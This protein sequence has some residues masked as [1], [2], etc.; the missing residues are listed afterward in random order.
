MS[1]F[2]L[3]LP[4]DR[5]P[6]DAREWRTAD[7]ARWTAAVPARWSHPLWAV[8]AL[9]AGLA[10]SI[11]AAPYEAC[12]TAQP[13]DTSWTYVALSALGLLTLYW[14]WRQPRLAVAGLLVTGGGAVMETGLTDVVT[15]PADLALLTALAFAAAGLVHRLAATHRQRA[16]AEEAAGPG[17]HPLPPEARPFRRGR[18]SFALASLLLAVTVFAVWRAE[19]IATAY[20]ER[21]A[22]AT[23]V[24]AEVTRIEIEDED[25]SEL[26][27]ALPD[28]G[29]RTVGV[30]FPEDYPVGST[31]DL[32]VDGDWARLVAEP[33]EVVGWELLALVTAVP[34]LGF[35]ANGTTGNRRQRRLDTG[36]LPVLKVLVREGHEDGRTWVY[37]ADDPLGRHPVLSFNSLY[38]SDSDEEAR[39]ED[40]PYPEDTGREPTE[41]EARAAR[42]EWE[43]QKEEFAAVLKGTD[44]PPPLREALLFGAPC[45]GGETAF[46]APAQEGG[47]GPVEA[48]RSVTPIRPVTPGLFAAGP[49]A[50]RGGPA[51]RRADSR[52]R[53]SAEVALTL[54]PGP[55]PLTWSADRGS[56]AL[57]GFLLLVQGGGMWALLDDGFSWQWLI[58]LVGVPWLVHSVSTALNWRITADRDGVWI[59]G[60]W[61]VRHVRWEDVAAVRHRADGV[62][63][64]LQDGDD[65]ELAPVGIGVDR[66]R[67]RGAGSSATRAAETLRALL[68]HPGLR[69]AEAAGP[70]E[71]G[72]PLGPVVVALAALWAA[73]V[74]LL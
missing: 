65:I 30:V 50:R 58:L 13:C 38:T 69:P 29:T 51:P 74:L 16:L 14:I 28:G 31:V 11:A 73:V 45:A 35:L 32:V 48:E 17:R 66:L 61:R 25:L 5:V 42:E 55:E 18:F 70:G 20:E 71:Q 4:Q 22:G 10:W 7:T 23:R 47:D 9:C 19:G 52:G 59:C 33:Y 44:A 46:L 24:A 2:P 6:E 26:T 27:A 49:F 62:V 64:T 1:D 68:D 63:I 8:I 40:G 41:E 39:Y 3:P 12:T 15:G 67:E 53:S 37:A 21:A 56:R 34:G 60:A 54:T 36:R 72:M 43:R 57:G